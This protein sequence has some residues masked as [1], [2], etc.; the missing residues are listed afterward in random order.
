MKKNREPVP[1]PKKNTVSRTVSAGGDAAKPARRNPATL[2]PGGAKSS[3]ELPP[4]HSHRSPSFGTVPSRMENGVSSASRHELEKAINQRATLQTSLGGV[5]KTSPQRPKP[6][7]SPSEATK[8][9]ILPKR[10]EP[11]KQGAKKVPPPRPSSSP[12]MKRKQYY[13]TIS[14][15]PGDAAGCLSFREGES[16][17]IIEK[18]C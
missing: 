5:K 16:V 18:K 1:G 12:T 6:P 7:P 10:P 8:R 4:T 14:D 2:H 17:E 15:Y 11:P 9:R 13:I 3:L